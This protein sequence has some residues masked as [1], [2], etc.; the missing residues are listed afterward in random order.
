[1]LLDFDIKKAIAAAAFFIEREHGTEDMY[2]LLKKLYWA[3]RLALLKWGKPIT[4]DSFAS[5]DKGPIVSGI[6]NLMK[7]KGLQKDLI[8][9]ND[10]I[11]RGEDY[12]ITLRKEADRG[13]LSEREIEVL[14]EARKTPR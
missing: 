13:A 2:V 1:M 6:Y 14:E 9:W 8:L 4:G 7:G 3:D 12:K 10:V 5:L 11:S